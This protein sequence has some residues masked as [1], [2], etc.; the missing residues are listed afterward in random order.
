MVA[1]DAS[2][3]ERKLWTVCSALEWTR[4]FLTRRGDEHPRLSAEWLLCAATGLS[5][6]DLYV[7]YDRPLDAAELSTLH[8]GVARRGRGEPLQYVTGEVGFRHIVLKCAPG[9]LIPRPETEILVDE[10]LSYLNERVAQA[11]VP[12]G[13][14]APLRVLEVGT[15][16]GCISLSIAGECPAARV[17]ATDISPTAVE[18]ATRNRDALG[19]A[20]SVDIVQ[21]DLATGVAGADDGAFDVLVSNPPYI[22][23]A[24]MA[25]LPREVGGFEP[26]LA[27]DGGPDGL[28]VFRRLVDLGTRALRPGGLLA[29][30]LHED[31]LVAASELPGVRAGYRDV[32]IVR[33]LTGRD[34]ILCA[35]RAGDAPDP[36]TAIEG[37]VEL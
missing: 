22:P 1:A 30:E 10:V 25:L 32:R 15:G 6:V 24:Q 27:L 18:L 35:V 17:V 9:V 19:L 29:C 37:E 36:R 26:A 20:G 31:T 13:P 8:D 3:G 12:A 2:N 28:D 23:S 11:D 34:R 5:R 21:A 33:D 4:D 14:P 7:N 16:T